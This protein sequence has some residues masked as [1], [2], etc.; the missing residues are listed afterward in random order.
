MAGGGIGEAALIGAALGGASS[1]IQ[2]G[3]PLEGALLGGI[4]G[5][6]GGALSGAGA[7]GAESLISS[8][9]ATAGVAESFAIPEAAKIAMT[10]LPN[11]VTPAAKGPISMYSS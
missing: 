4:T 11:A 5:G 1:A 6:A 3:N 8:A 10:E 7:A 2:G 9:P